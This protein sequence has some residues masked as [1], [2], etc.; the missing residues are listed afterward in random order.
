LLLAYWGV[1]ALVALT[2]A[3]VVRFADTGIDGAVLAFTLGVSIATSL[4][5]GLVPAFHAS[6]VDLID[7][8]KQ[9]GT[10]AVF[11]GRSIRTRGVLVVS[12]IALAVVL[13]TGAGLLLKSLMALQ[14][15][16]LGFQ[17]AHALVMKATG[18]RGAEENNAY[19]EEIL[20]R[21]A[22][23]PGVVAVGATSTP[24]GDL[25]HAGSGAHF[26]D[27]M[28]VR[29]RATEPSTLLTIV[30]PGSFAALGIPLKSGRD[31]NEEDTGNRP[32]VAIVNEALVR[33]SMAG[34]NPIGRTIFCT[35][36]RPDGMTIVGVVG[37][38]RQRNPAIEPGP[39][40]YMPYRQHGYN[41]N[42]LNVVIRTA[43]DPAALAGAVRRVAADVSP[44]VPVS[45]TTMDATVSER[46]QDPRF[47]AQLFGLFAGLAVCLAMAGVYGVMAYAVEQRSKEIG[48]RMALGADRASVLRLILG[49]GFALAATGLVLGLAGAVAA[50]RLLETV[51]FQVRP[52]DISVYVAVVLVLGLG[53]FAAGYLP[54]WRA[55]VVDPVKVLKAE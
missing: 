31:F 8:L 18:N 52:I 3:D 40:C 46:V 24:P 23:L 26:I 41:N 54:A 11:G 45:F 9:G 39:E 21:I 34:E 5:F 36:D 28:P 4:L 51:L 42:T 30:A 6:R 16:D 13:L 2:P 33:K 47:R 55:A 50:T 49:Q 44:E 10:R 53:T 7:A 14:N 20:S 32:L 48:L 17:P 19:F 25:N 12:E 35:F 29:D 15:V 22:A 37:D 27:R 43:G 38:V 1:K